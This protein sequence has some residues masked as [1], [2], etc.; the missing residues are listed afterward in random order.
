MLIPNFD[1]VYAMF[2]SIKEIPHKQ[3]NLQGITTIDS[4]SKRDL[5]RTAAMAKGF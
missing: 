4:Y 3:L 5:N 2:M 1:I